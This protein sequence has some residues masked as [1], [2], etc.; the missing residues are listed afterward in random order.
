[1]IFLGCSGPGALKPEMVETMAEQPIILAL[2]NPTHE[3]LPE[4]AKAVRPDAIIATGRSD[5]PNQVNNVL[6]FPFLFRG[7]LDVGATEI[8]EEMK[9]ACAHA[10]AGLARKEA[11]DIVLTAYGAES[12]S[13][14]PDYIIPKPFDPR[15]ITELAPAVAQAAMDSGAATR[16]IEDFDAY[17]ER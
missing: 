5:Y 6:C 16:P 3:I 14:G 4:E 10:I 9:K 1:Y 11:S 15:L 17:R 2:A 7:A 8:N 13:F 12:F